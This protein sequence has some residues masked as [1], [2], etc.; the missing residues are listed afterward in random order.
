[1]S[2]S[3][4]GKEAKPKK[5]MPTAYILMTKY[6]DGDPEITGVFSSFDKAV[7]NFVLTEFVDEEIGKEELLLNATQV[8][9]KMAHMTDDEDYGDF[10]DTR[11]WIEE[12]EFDCACDGSEEEGS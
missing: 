4:K 3:K 8:A 5:K 2:N 12:H 7:A 11:A 9:L 10:G 1:M 6:K